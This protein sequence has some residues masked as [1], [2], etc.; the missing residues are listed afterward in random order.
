MANT[1]E[2]VLKAKDQLSKLASKSFNSVRQA[3]DKARRFLN[4]VDGPDRGRGFER[5]ARK[6]GRVN[7]LLQDQ[8][9]RLRAIQRA[10]FRLNQIA[11]KRARLQSKLV[12]T[13]A[14]SV[15]AA[16]PVFTAAQTE[17]TEIRLRTVL[18]T[19]NIQRGLALARRSAVDLAKTG[20]TRIREALEIQYQLNSAGL[21]AEAAR[22]ADDIVAK[23]AKV[24]AGLPGEVA[25]VIATSY[26]NLAETL[27]GTAQDK[28]SRIAELL[29]KV[30]FKFQIDNFA[31]IGQSL[32]EGASGIAAAKVPLNQALTILGQLNSAGL[33]GSRAGTA[34][35]AVLR[36]L[37][38]AQEE[39]GFEITRSADGQLDLLGTLEKLKQSLASFDNLDER[40]S[41]L[42]TAFGDE[43][44]QGVVPLLSKLDELKGALKDVEDGSRG[45]VD[46]NA[47]LFTG[48]TLGLARQ[49]GST[50]EVAGNNIGRVLLPGV[51]AVLAPLASFLS[52]IADLAE[53]FPRITATIGG[54]L[55][56][57]VALRAAILAAQFVTLTFSATSI[58]AFKALAI[59]SAANPV[60]LILGGIAIVAALV[61][62]NWEKVQAFFVGIWEP[63]KAAWNRFLAYVQPLID[64]I[65]RPIK[66]FSSFFGFGSAAGTAGSGNG[67]TTGPVRARPPASSVLAA[68][69]GAGGGSQIN[70]TTEIKVYQQPGEDGQAFAERVARRLQS[71]DA[72]L[73]TD[74]VG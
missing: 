63:V 28:F 71:E 47:K 8:E 38:K 37:T 57:L 3:A 61:I 24:T 44:L 12:G 72:D 74:P 55:T 46:T 51:N 41:A 21:S 39:F 70:K 50:L 15:A 68:Q 27:P 62:A 16:A 25:K 53:R 52:V 66:A 7:R 22:A 64:R 14:Q 18:N 34:L 23:T 30:Q 35:R 69:A 73:L 31:Q 67:S 60:L 13:A 4:R 2:I 43:G 6:V 56:A 29:T 49:F 59:A 33:G 42:Q 9:F 26:N 1:L 45:I 58:A 19:D 5:M 54:I 40:N 48:S 65:T 32:T 17:E 20:L 10:E 11:D 36:S